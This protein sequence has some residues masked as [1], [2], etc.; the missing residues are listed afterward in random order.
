MSLLTNQIIFHQD[1]AGLFSDER[2]ITPCDSTEGFAWYLCPA[3]LADEQVWLLVNAEF[4]YVELLE[5]VDFSAE[6]IEQ[7]LLDVI[8]LHL[9]DEDELNVS[10]SLDPD[11]I[12]WHTADKIPEHVAQRYQQALL[13]LDSCADILAALHALEQLNNTA[14]TVSGRTFAPSEGMEGLLAEL[15]DDYRHYKGTTAWYKRQWDLLRGK[16]PWLL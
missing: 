6:A 3:V 11:D 5:Q 10:V 4:G 2:S 1:L 9:P 15:A 16:R 7:A 12:T 13:L 8:E 14:W